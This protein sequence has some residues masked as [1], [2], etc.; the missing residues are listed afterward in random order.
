MGV[1]EGGT[2]Y[3]DVGDE[4]GDSDNGSEGGWAGG[5]VEE[6]VE[7]LLSLTFRKVVSAYY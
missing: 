3:V 2:G 1:E 6:E 5:M 4:S 7:I